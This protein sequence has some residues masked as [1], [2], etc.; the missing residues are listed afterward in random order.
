M[1]ERNKAG[2]R[3]SRSPPFAGKKILFFTKKADEITFSANGSP[4]D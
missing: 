1:T 2:L 3:S 4:A